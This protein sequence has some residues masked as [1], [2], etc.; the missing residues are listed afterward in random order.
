MSFIF[1]W[2]TVFSYSL[3]IVVLSVLP[4]K[5]PKKLV[6]PY[7]DNIIHG[8]M[9]LLLSLV[10]VNTLQKYNFKRVKFFS[11]SYAFGLG[12][13]LELVQFFLPYRDFQASDIISNALGA[14]FGCLIQ[15]V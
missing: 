9:Y 3:L 6:F 11:F 15:V 14:F 1:S 10:I 13:M 8:L 4:V 5:A 2:F 12:F 7:S